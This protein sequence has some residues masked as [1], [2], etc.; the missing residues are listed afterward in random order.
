VTKVLPKSSEATTQATNPNPAVA[1]SNVEV[2]IENHFSDGTL[3][4]SIDDKLAYEHPLRDG[5]KKKLILLGGG[6]KETVTI[7]LASGKHTLRVEVRSRK[8]QYDESKTVAG[9]FLKGGDK[10][11]SITFDKHSREMQVAL[12]ADLTSHLAQ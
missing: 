9:D 12:S 8:E 2:H 6:V 4:I 10:V 5:H 11:L 1:D 3:S 7:P